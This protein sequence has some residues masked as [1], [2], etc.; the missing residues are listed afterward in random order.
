[1]PTASARP[2]ATSASAVG[3]VDDAG[4]GDDRH[5]DRG[6]TTSSGSPMA[7]PLERRWR[8]TIQLD[9]A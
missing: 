1:M 6:R 8:R 3:E 9:A 7:R 5:V 4:R 2:L